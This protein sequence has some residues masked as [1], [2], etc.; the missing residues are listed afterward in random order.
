MEAEVKTCIF[1]AGGRE[2]CG[3]AAEERGRQ[4]DVEAV[5]RCGG[6]GRGDVHVTSSETDL[7]LINR[8]ASP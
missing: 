4:L 6:C 5:Y 1:E 8:I 2:S 7:A 3:F